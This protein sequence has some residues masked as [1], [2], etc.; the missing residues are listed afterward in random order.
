MFLFSRTR[1]DGKSYALFRCNKKENLGWYVWMILWPKLLNQ[2][3]TRCH[4]GQ[5]FKLISGVMLRRT[6]GRLRAPR[7]SGSGKNRNRSQSL[8]PRVDDH[9]QLFRAKEKF[10]SP[11]RFLGCKCRDYKP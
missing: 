5:N 2:K 8:P 7:W 10:R 9:H 6:Y 4:H 1:L 3:L 11:C